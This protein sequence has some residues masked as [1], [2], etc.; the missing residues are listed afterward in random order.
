[1][2][3]DRNSALSPQLGIS[4]NGV[5]FVLRNVLSIYPYSYVVSEYLIYLHPFTAV[6]KT[7]RNL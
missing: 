6:L 7:P 4:P 1:M 5:D 3:I 2:Y